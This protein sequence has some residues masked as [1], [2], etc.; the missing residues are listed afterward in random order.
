MKA[1]GKLMYKYKLLLLLN[2]QAE[3]L[4]RNHQN[5]HWLNLQAVLLPISQYMRSYVLSYA[6][7]VEICP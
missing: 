2:R 4:G 1:L 5:D 6:K 7:C 3:Y